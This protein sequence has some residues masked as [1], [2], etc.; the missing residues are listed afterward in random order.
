MLEV[1]KTLMFVSFQTVSS[2]YVNVKLSNKK[3]EY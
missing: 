3:L 1:I 2:T